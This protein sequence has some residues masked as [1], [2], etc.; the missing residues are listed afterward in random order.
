MEYKYNKELHMSDPEIQ[1]IMRR[2]RGLIRRNLWR[3]IYKIAKPNTVLGDIIY[4]SYRR[5]WL[6]GMNQ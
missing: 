2:H 5:G 1:T 4:V 6:D 3:F